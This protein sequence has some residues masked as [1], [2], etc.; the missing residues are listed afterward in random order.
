MVN[1]SINERHD[2]IDR[3]QLVALA[4]LMLLGTA[5][6]YSA[7]MA[8]PMEVTKAWYSQTWFH[9]VIWYF[10]GL[11]TG[12]ALCLVDY[13]HAGVKRWSLVAYW[14]MFIC[15]IAVLVPHI[16][17]DA[18]RC[19]ALDSTLVSFSFSRVNFAKLAF[20]PGDREF[21]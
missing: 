4:G 15:L 18:V 8:N 9:Q 11:G 2:R 5:F 21:P 3:T 1:S 13:H 10:L 14:A 16:G 6:V 7:T 20:I 12:A 17:S 19:A